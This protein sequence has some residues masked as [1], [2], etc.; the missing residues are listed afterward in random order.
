MSRGG[1]TRSLSKSCTPLSL[2]YFYFFD[3]LIDGF[4]IETFKILANGNK[5][6]GDL[7][8]IIMTE[9]KY[10]PATWLEC[11][12]CDDGTRAK[13]EVLLLKEVHYKHARLGQSTCVAS[14]ETCP[15]PLET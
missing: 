2:F 8:V 5:N 15:T 11:K 14:L 1:V 10:P 6:Q 9:F 12:L 4:P 13:R 7:H 3:R